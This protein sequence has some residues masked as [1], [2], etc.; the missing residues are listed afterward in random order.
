MARRLTRAEAKEQTRTKLL[1]SASV[2]FR[3]KGYTAAT[4]EEIAERAGFTRGAFYANFS[5]KA[6]LFMTLLETDRAAAMA[7]VTELVETTPDEEKLAAIQDWFDRL[8]GTGLE[9]PYAEFWPQAM[10][11]KAL[12]ARLARR[13][14]GMRAAIAHMVNGYCRSAGVTLGMPV[15]ELASMILALGDGV[16]AQRSLEPKLRSDLFTVAAAHLWA[17]AVAPVTSS[18]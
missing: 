10:R 14:G 15:E 9:L 13:Q 16:A 2:V 12:R 6:D 18:R 7:E 17:G 1:A 5:D 3:R 4:V 8:G 11:D